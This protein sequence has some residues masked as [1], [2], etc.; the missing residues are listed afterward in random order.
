MKY[1]WCDH[2]ELEALR[3]ENAQLKNE[4]NKLTDEIINLKKQCC[5]DMVTLARGAGRKRGKN[6]KI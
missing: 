3:V 6:E 2:E 5:Y 1:Y 4:I